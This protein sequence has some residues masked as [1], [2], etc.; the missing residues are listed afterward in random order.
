M[1]DQIEHHGANRARNHDVLRMSPSPPV[2]HA[3][4]RTSPWHWAHRFSQG[5]H[6]RGGALSAGDGALPERRPEFWQPFHP[7]H[8]LQHQPQEQPLR[9]WHDK[10][11]GP[12]FSPASKGVDPL[13]G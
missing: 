4:P 5:V 9:A 12:P 6:A 11:G 1:D 13:A 3:P 2:K 10:V 8:Q 7:P